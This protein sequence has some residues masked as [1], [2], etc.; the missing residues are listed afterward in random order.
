[1]DV[2]VNRA[3]GEF[4]TEWVLLGPFVG[5]RGANLHVDWDSP[6]DTGG[7]DRDFLA[8]LGGEAA[9]VIH[10]GSTVTYSPRGGATRTAAARRIGPRLDAGLPPDF[11]HIL[12]GRHVLEQDFDQATGYAFCLLHSGR[13]QSAVA[14]LGS[15]GA[16]RVLV[17]G[18]V[19]HE[20][21]RQRKTRP[22]QDT[23]RLPLRAGDNRLLVKIDNKFDWWGFQLAVYE[24]G[25]QPAAA[26][27]APAPA[28]AY[29]GDFA[30]AR[31]AA[32]ER[33]ARAA[34]AW[35][36]L[37]GAWH[38]LYAGAV[39]WVRRFLAGEIFPDVDYRSVETLKYVELLTAA[40]ERGENFLAS[41]DCAGRAIA[42]WFDSGPHSGAYH[43]FL[44]GGFD[45]QG[46]PLP[47]VIDL[48]GS[49]AG[50][51]LY[52]LEPSNTPA[53][54]LDGPPIA[55]IKP[56]TPHAGW[57]VDYLNAVLADARGRLRI[58]AERVY[59]QGGSMGGKG[60]WDW[61]VAH[62]EH[63][64]AA[65]VKCGADGQ[66]FRAGRLRHVPVW[67][68]NGE[69]DLASY[70]FMPELM[71]TAIRRAGGEAEY[72]L[73]PDLAHGMGAAIDQR[74]VKQW[75]LSHRRSPGTPPPDPLRELGIG[76]DGA[77][78]TAFVDVP[79]FHALALAGQEDW[80]WP[81]DN[82]FRSAVKLYQA[83]RKPAGERPARLADGLVLIRASCGAGDDR[84][85]M[86]LAAPQAGQA[87]GGALQAVA[88][89]PIRAARLYVRGTWEDLELA[90]RRLCEEL[91]S[92]GERPT[93]E[94]RA[95]LLPC[96]L[97]DTAHYWELQVALG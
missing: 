1:M 56:I 5:P 31:R 85:R 66:T 57:R 93:G 39:A 53:V 20:V 52:P 8:P 47:L 68:F 41:P 94:R 4:L 81:Q 35:Q 80:P 92:R 22:F 64:A 75:F 25:R 42:V 58:D 82:V 23:F 44:P 12:D 67:V 21:R 95:I 36:D 9:A 29:E 19:A 37:P 6:D 43:V 73:F 97:R 89:P 54:P 79:A 60:T 86:L 91:A 51:R 59:L 7:L 87:A 28:A 84:R 10:P 61:A 33:F 76:H 38:G 3:G 30:A 70:P 18:Q 65:C 50:R 96:G 15:D 16:T 2:P 90:E 14:C 88:L 77:S 49:G 34:D 26:A 55:A 32:R 78:E 27:A 74:A 69:K 45:P 24:E 48:H 72:T 13:E 46:P 11:R 17:N 83:Y 71:V 40:M 63:F 62:P